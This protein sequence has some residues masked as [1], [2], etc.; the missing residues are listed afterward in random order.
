MLYNASNLAAG[1]DSGGAN[2]ANHDVASHD[3]L[4]AAKRSR[5]TQPG[6]QQRVNT[7]VSTYY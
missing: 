2:A 5:S 4:A 7:A 1:G 3:I 6:F